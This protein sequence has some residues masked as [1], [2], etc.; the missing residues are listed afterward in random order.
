MSAVAPVEHEP[1]SA[2]GHAH[3]EDHHSAFSWVGTVD[4]KRIGILYL[5]TALFF[6]AVGGTE[7]LIMRL[8][9]AR[10]NNTLVGPDTFN[11]LFTMHGTTMIFL[12]VMPTL[13]GFGNYFVPLMIGAR[14]MA[15]PRLNAMSYWLFPFGGFLLHFSVLAGGAPS[16][17]WFAYAPLTETPFTSSPGTD[18]WILALLVLGVG[19]VATAINFIATILT[20]RAPGMTMGRVPLFVWMTFFTS[21]LVV[22]ALPVLNASIVMLLVDRLLDAHFFLA[23]GGGNTLLWQ[24]FFWT[25]GHPEVYI[26]ALPAFG[27]ISEIVPVFSRKPIFGHAFI[28]ASTVAIAILSFGVWAHHMFGVGL[29]HTADVF[30]VGGTMLIAVPTGVKIFNWIATMWGGSIR[31]DTPMLYATAFLVEFVIGGLSGITFA[32]APIDWQ[33]TDTYYVVAHFHYVAIGGTA[34]AVLGALHYWF[35]KMSGRMLSERL[36]KA[37][38]WLMV[39]GFNMTFFVQHFLGIMGMPRRVFTYPDL[40]GWAALNLVSTIGAVLMGLASL[41]L[42]INILVSLR[43]GKLAGDNPWEGWSLEWATTSPPPHDN[44][45]EVPII[46]GRRP[47]WDLTHPEK[48]AKA[49]VPEERTYDKGAIAVW[50]FIASETGFFLILIIAFVF[51]NFR[52]S[53]GGPS[54][55]SVLDVQKTAGFTVCLF[56]SSGTLWLS[57][58]RLDKKDVTGATVW[59]LLT[60]ILGGIFIVGQGS[61]YLGLYHRGVGVATNLFA[62]TFF[63]L[64][65]FHGLH[66]TVGLFA[67]AIALA[68]VRATDFKARAPSLLKAIGLYWHFVDVVWLV[69]FTVVYLRPLS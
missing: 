19:S 64:T 62:T 49:A 31:F 65:G 32:A 61:E 44:F 17:G 13:V 22:L 8:Q 40:P 59:L 52:S 38:F 10:P 51:F 11:Q 6:F 68:L 14:D 16:A 42:V 39:I 5:F 41:L 29:G 18:Y 46:T 24:H 48:D 28:A 27:M 60:L 53:A 15:F 2:H 7:A 26:L 1:H 58:K 23:N 54:A 35:P 20:L 57:E 67:L 4:H 25:F 3:A 47:L 37:N 69:V 45:S 36:G 9:L 12:V 56:A 50:S 34:F 33:M 66:V 55:A 43:S 30:F 63:T 21:I